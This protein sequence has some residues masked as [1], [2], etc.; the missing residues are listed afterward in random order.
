MK[1]LKI[2]EEI[3]NM[4]R[5]EQILS[6]ANNEGFVFAYEITLFVFGAH[7]ADKHP[8]DETIMRVLNCIG[9][10]ERSWIDTVRENWDKVIKED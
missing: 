5:E 7:W 4:T 3:R 6:A 2:G 1:E 8:S 10:E 9:Y